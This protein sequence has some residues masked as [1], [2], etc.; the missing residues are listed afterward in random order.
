MVS[1]RNFAFAVRNLCVH[2][3]FSEQKLWINN[4]TLFPFRLILFIRSQS[5][6]I[7]AMFFYSWMDI[8]TN[9]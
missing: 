5:T 1:I 2:L 7:S 3:V 4:K 9:V 6:W 8:E